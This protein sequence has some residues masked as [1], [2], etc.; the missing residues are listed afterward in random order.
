MKVGMT[1][2]AAGTALIIFAKAPVAGQVKTRLMPALG[3]EGAARLAAGLLEHTVANG[4]AAGFET[5]ELCTAPD[6]TH[7][8]FVELA[9]QYAGLQLTVQGDGDL[10]AR[11]HRALARRL[12]DCTRVLLIGTDAPALDAAM[13]R[14][15][16]QALVAHDAVWIPAHDGGYALVGLSSPQPALFSDMT[17]STPDVMTHTRDRA[18]AA[19][20]RWVELPAVADI[21]EPADLAHL[22]VGWQR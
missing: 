2:A 11:M 17:W 3:P 1:H 14:A 15:A 4:M 16:G 12:A 9:D 19:G 13:L 8:A 18:R 7:G 6:A 22:P 20:L 10:G 21:D 5:V